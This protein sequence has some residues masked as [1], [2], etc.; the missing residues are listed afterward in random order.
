MFSHLWLHMLLTL[1]SR[2][3]WP[4]SAERHHLLPW[5]PIRLLGMLSNMSPG[6][7]Q[8]HLLSCKHLKN[9]LIH[10]TWR[11]TSRQPSYFASTVFISHSGMIGHL[12]SRQNFSLPNR[13]IIGI[14]CSGT[15]MPS[16][17]FV[18]L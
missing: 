10:G 1:L 15:M 13:F 6:P 11:P 4:V 12:Q 8:P 14:K 17:V 7:R 2:Q 3:C 16:G 5:P 9:E 18:W